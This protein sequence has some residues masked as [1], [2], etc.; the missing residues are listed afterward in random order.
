[1]NCTGGK[2]QI[3]SDSRIGARTN[4]TPAKTYHRKTVMMI[5]ARVLFSNNRRGQ[6]RRH[7]QKSSLGHGTG[8]ARPLGPDKIIF[9]GLHA[10]GQ[11]R[12]SQVL[13]P[14]ST[15]TATVIRT[16]QLQDGFGCTNVTNRCHCHW[17]P[18]G[19]VPR[20]GTSVCCFCDPCSKYGRQAVLVDSPMN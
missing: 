18:T 2:Q 8:Y 6:L 17:L 10:L 9:A 20:C 11:I 12:A 1:M 7:A 16:L 4:K 15:G 13:V 5:N 3:K 14:G 19:Q